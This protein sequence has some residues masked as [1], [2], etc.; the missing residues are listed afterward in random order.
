M[1]P[2]VGLSAVGKRKVTVLAGRRTSSVRSGVYSLFMT[3]LCLTSLVCE[4]FK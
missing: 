1:D 2:R 3:E 4:Y